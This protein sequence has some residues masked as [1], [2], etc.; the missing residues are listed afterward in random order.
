MTT[1]VKPALSLNVA[2]AKPTGELWPFMFWCHA[3]RP[4][5]YRDSHINM[6]HIS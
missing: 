2:I 4:L 6:Y 3:F 5:S 1:D